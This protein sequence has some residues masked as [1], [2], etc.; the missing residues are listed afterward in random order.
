M[1]HLDG[2]VRRFVEDTSNELLNSEADATGVHK[3]LTL[4][5]HVF[6]GSSHG[7]SRQGMTPFTNLF[8]TL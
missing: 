1:D 8:C 4:T 5:P 7:V 2:L 6:L 3:F